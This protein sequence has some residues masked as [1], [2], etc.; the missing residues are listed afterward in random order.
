MMAAKTRPKKA[1]ALL[2]LE[3]ILTLSKNSG[4]LKREWEDFAPFLYLFIGR[5]SKRERNGSNSNMATKTVR[6]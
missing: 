2:D 1:N 4:C 5:N 6:T 3:L